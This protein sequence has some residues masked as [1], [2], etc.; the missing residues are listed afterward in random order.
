MKV[1]RAGALSVSVAVVIAGS[2]AATFPSGSAP[3][4]ASMQPIRR[5]DTVELMVGDTLHYTRGLRPRPNNFL[6]QSSN[7]DV[8]SVIPG[9]ALVGR[10]SGLVTLTSTTPTRLGT[11]LIFVRVLTPKQATNKFISEVCANVDS[12]FFIDTLPVSTELPLIHEYHDCQRLIKTDHSY[13]AVVGIYATRQ[14]QSYETPLQYTSGRLVAIIVNFVGTKDT[15]T[16]VP[17]GIKPGV[18]CLIVRSVVSIG[19][20]GSPPAPAFSWQAAIIPQTMAAKDSLGVHYGD[21]PDSLNWNDV[22]PSALNKLT[23]KP[24]LGFDLRDQPLAPPVARWDWDSTNH[25]NYMGVKCS[26]AI[27]CEIGPSTGYTQSVARLTQTGRPVFKGFYD[28]Q[29]LAD[30]T[31]GPHPSSVFGTITPGRDAKDITQMAAH[32]PAVWYHTSHLDLRETTP[33]ASA[34]YGYY[35]LVFKAIATSL[36]TSVSNVFL[37]P[38]TSDQL[39][40]YLG[41]MN[42]VSLTYPQEIIY[43]PHFGH[44]NVL[45]PTVRWRWK[46]KDEGTWSYCHPQGCCE[47]MVSGY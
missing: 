15:T 28:E 27:W 10:T 8:A 18:N 4:R 6:L 23:V 43:T 33:T 20:R 9:G 31:G 13:S 39:S 14:V 35:K 40:G 30:T 11:P 42:S 32:D 22:P 44:Q 45:V 12:P 16:Y 46:L 2:L 1:F 47:D 29:Y 38:K 37:K 25:Q 36:L 5:V 34:A 21:C 17:L 26:K 41:R 7:A 19:R 24:Q 3:E